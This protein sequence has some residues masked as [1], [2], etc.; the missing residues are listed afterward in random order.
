[1]T[2]AAWAGSGS[3]WGD[4][5]GAPGEVAA[6]AAADRGEEA[7]AEEEDEERRKKRRSGLLRASRFSVSC[8]LRGR[9]AYLSK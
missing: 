7:E 9:G 3:G 8:Y 1:M 5:V 2:H 4:A 6:V